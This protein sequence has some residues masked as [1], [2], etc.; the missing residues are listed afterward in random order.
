[1]TLHATARGRTQVPASASDFFEQ[2][3]TFHG[4]K[5]LSFQIRAMDSGNIG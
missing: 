1:M 5:G 3:F 2:D 4:K